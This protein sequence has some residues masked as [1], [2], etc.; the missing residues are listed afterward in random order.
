MDTDTITRQLAERGYCIAP[1][2]WP[3][4]R[5]LLSDFEGERKA[6]HFR[7]AGVGRG[8]N[9]QR[10]AQL[11][12]DEI[13]WWESPRIAQRALWEQWESLRL[14]VNRELMLGAFDF[15][16]HYSYYDSGAFYGRHLDR[17]QDDDR[18]VLSLILYLN[19]NWAA[20]DG[21][22]LKL[23]VDENPVVRPE[24]GTL[25]CFLSD[26]IPHEVM[27]T[28]RPRRSVAGWF[29]RRLV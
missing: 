8:E 2:F 27:P 15:E 25:V 14:A 17:F 18:R 5:T 3:E 16:A 1:D 12:R 21:G 24:G 26:R 10:A 11:R 29:R 6:G 9:R 13:C 19:E 4:W 28:T 23:Y 7:E 20:A 22:E